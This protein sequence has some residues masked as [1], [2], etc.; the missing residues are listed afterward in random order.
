MLVLKFV[1]N[2]DFTISRT[3]LGGIKYTEGLENILK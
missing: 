3:T 1:I 2:A